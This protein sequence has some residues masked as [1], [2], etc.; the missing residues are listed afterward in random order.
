M[1]R[2]THPTRLPGL[3]HPTRLDPP[4]P[5][6]HSGVDGFNDSPG[7]DVSSRTYVDR[8]DAY[9]AYFM[10]RPSGAEADTIWVTIGVLRWSWEG[11]AEWSIIGGWAVG[12]TDFDPNPVGTE[13]N[14]PP[15]WTTRYG[16]L[17]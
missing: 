3:I 7:T 14:L 17:E 5:A 12:P 15:E 9:E 13:N 11:I 2:L 6:G 8:T 10:Y 1:L 16:N 4:Y